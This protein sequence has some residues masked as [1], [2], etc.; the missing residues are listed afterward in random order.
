M[1]TESNKVDWSEIAGAAD[2]AAKPLVRRREAKAHWM[3][4]DEAAHDL[5]V[6][7]TQL[8]ASLVKAHLGHQIRYKKIAYHGSLWQVNREAFEQWRERTGK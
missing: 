8:R 3:P 2:E 1:L 7:S 4:L 6:T 5:G